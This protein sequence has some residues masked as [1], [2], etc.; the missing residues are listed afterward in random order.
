MQIISVKN[1]SMH[2]F[3]SSG[4]YRRLR[5]LTGIN[6]VH[7]STKARG[8]AATPHHRRWGISPRPETEIAYFYY[9]HGRII[10][11]ARGGFVNLHQKIIWTV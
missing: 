1:Y 9:R 4:L 6:S 7:L 10:C 8:L 11:Q 2:L 5:I 3:L